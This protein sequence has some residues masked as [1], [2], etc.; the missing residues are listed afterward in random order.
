MN[1]YED[2]A[3]ALPIFT[4]H[5]VF[6]LSGIEAKAYHIQV[7]DDPLFA[8]PD[9][10]ASTENLSAMPTS[11]A[12]LQANQTY[13]W[14]VCST[15]SI[16]GACTSPWSQI[17]I[18]Q[19]NPSKMLSETPTITLL[20][21][22]DKA[23]FVE[24]TPLLEWFPLQ[25]ADSY[26][27]Q[28]GQDPNFNETIVDEFTEYPAFIPTTS[29]AQ[30][31]L[32][33]LDFGTFYWRVRGYINGSS[34]GGWSPIWRFIISAQSQWRQARTL[35][36]VDNQLQIGSD[37]D[38]LSDQ[39][40]ELVTLYA[41]QDKDYWYFGFNAYTGSTMEYGLYLDLDSQDN[42]GAITDPRGNNVSTISLHRPEYAIYILQG[43]GGGFSASNTIVYRWVNQQWANNPQMLDSIGGSLIYDDETSYLEIRV[44]NTA[45]GMGEDTS[46]ASLTLFSVDINSHTIM[47]CVPMSTNLSVLDRLASVSE[48][49]NLGTPP[50]N[51]NS[52][53]TTYSSVPPFFFDYPINTPWEGYTIQITL[54]PLFTTEK[55]L[56]QLT[57]VGN[58]PYYAPPFYTEHTKT[59][60]IDGDNTYYWRVRPQYSVTPDQV[61][62]GAWSQ[63]KAFEREGFVPQ[64]LRESISF[65]TPTFTWDI[66][67]GAESY[68]LQVDSDPNFGTPDININTTNNSYTPITTL[69]NGKYYW[70]VRIRRYTLN[71]NGNDW[72]PA[73]PFTL[74][75]PKPTGLTPN[76][77]DEMNILRGIPTLCWDPLVTSIDDT[78]VMAAY[79]YKVQV[80]KGDPTF[81]TIY[82]S[83]ETE[84]LCWTPTKGYDDGKYYWRVAMLD[85]NSPS[86]QGDYSSAAIFT[87]QY[88][89]AVPNNMQLVITLYDAPIF[90]WTAVDG[91]TPYVHGAA[92]YRI[93]ISKSSTYSPLYDSLTT[94]NTTYIPT[95]KYEFN[96]TYYWR[97]AIID[98][99][100]KYG[101][102]SNEVLIPSIL[103]LPTVIRAP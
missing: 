64:N 91:S 54:D 60:D 95:K 59:Q 16:G 41:T 33:K 87:K 25:S 101:P 3:V 17:W 43:D 53:P 11:I 26:R 32:N 61:I 34:L 62:A 23:E 63:P 98:K 38:D 45:I 66:V 6:D 44:P 78:P 88:P 31:N 56:Y 9:W 50:T 76:D 93:E 49:L 99:D 36:D 103:F 42:S 10:E 86:R 5:R 97:V 67:E 20:R 84:Q 1:P 13:Y 19:I 55:R 102:F 68:D 21:P 70:R 29:L 51:V 27:V 72:S 15:E 4:W 81:S 85:G 74:N 90:T 65:A 89:V 57:T 92:S 12:S 80:S 48:R 82:D 22:S 52:D 79:K 58:T 18:T 100:G 39:N 71:E 69:A 77:P 46:S 8:S 83:I 2:R 28:I 24:M 94:N 30:R 75:L 37:A 7:D 96:Q 47:D 35:G 14:R 40:Y 73:K